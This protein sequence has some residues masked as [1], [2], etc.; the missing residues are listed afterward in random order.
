MLAFEFNF[1]FVEFVTGH[2]DGVGRAVVG[3]W[4]GV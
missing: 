2:T 4:G 1:L 3:G